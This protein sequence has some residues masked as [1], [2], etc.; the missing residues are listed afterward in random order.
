MA[1]QIEVRC[2]PEM[3]EFIIAALQ[4]F[5]ESHYPHAAD[6]CSAAARE[7]MLDLVARFRREL[8]PGGSSAYSRRIRAFICEAVNGYAQLVE[9]RDGVSYSWRA[10]LAVAVCR[11]ECDD[12]GYAEAEAQDRAASLNGQQP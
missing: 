8:L 3:A 1:L 10:V 11:G 9:A 4:W 2:Q 6:E 12:S 5:V 7:A